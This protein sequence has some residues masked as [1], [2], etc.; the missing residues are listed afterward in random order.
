MNDLRSPFVR[1][2]GRK[3][4]FVKNMKM[5]NKKTVL[6]EPKLKSYLLKV[7]IVFGAK[8]LIK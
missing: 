2:R 6:S 5:S 7:N 1:I 3:K 8:F 4:C